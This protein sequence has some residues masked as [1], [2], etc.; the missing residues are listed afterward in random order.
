M[1]FRPL[2]SQWV[3]NPDPFCQG[4]LLQ[5]MEKAMRTQRME[6]FATG[7]EGIDS[8]DGVSEVN[9]TTK[10]ERRRKIEDLFEEKRLR[11]ELTEFA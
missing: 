3:A 9:P 6:D 2:H 7:N 11:E 10:L 4:V 5:A 1:K 8:K